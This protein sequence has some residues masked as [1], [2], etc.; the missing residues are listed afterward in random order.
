MIQGKGQAK[1]EL[2]SLGA[3]NSEKEVLLLDTKV[4][5]LKAEISVVYMR[6]KCW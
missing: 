2:G 3:L 6:N 4:S 1:L 5:I